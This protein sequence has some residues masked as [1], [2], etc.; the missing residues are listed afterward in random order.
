MLLLTSQLGDYRLSK[1]VTA[2]DWILLQSFHAAL[3]SMAA[4]CRLTLEAAINRAAFVWR[5]Q[6]WSLTII[7]VTS[8]GVILLRSHAS[9]WCLNCFC[10]ASRNIT[11]SILTR[12]HLFEQIWW[13][14]WSFLLRFTDLVPRMYQRLAPLWKT[15]NWC[16][17][18]R[19]ALPNDS[20]CI[21]LNCWCAKSELA[22]DPGSILFERSS[23][24]LRI[25]HV[26][27]LHENLSLWHNMISH[28]ISLT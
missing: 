8:Y 20:L 16:K 19:S 27:H 5:Y 3:S 24:I 18:Q 14:T 26:L 25:H 15:R 4:R 22:T 1:M 12:V 9:F 28:A 11:K 10:T 23:I 7:D 13:S 6:G 2:Y 21:L 17:I